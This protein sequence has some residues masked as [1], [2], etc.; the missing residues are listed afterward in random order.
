LLY[1]SGA[2]ALATIGAAAAAR[3]HRQLVAWVTSHGTTVPFAHLL[4]CRAGRK[5]SSPI[6]MSSSRSRHK[7]PARYAG[8]AH[9]RVQAGCDDI[10]A[11]IAVDFMRPFSRRCRLNVP[12]P[13]FGTTVK[14]VTRVR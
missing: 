9:P 7:A 13:D 12:V 6:A 1:P 10:S 3:P 11:L 14:R 8:G 2:E 4:A 5:A